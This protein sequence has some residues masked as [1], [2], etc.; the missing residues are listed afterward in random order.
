MNTFASPITKE[1]GDRAICSY[2][3]ISD[4]G[5]GGVLKKTISSIRSTKIGEGAPGA[6]F[7]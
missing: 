1:L 3:T 4:G 7:K 2:T 6:A 5:W